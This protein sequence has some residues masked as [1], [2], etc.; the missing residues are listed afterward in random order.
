MQNVMTDEARDK[1]DTRY[2]DLDNGNR[3]VFSK[4]NSPY[5]FWTV[6]FEKGGKPFDL[7]GS[8]TSYD[9]AVQAFHK[10]L[11]TKNE[12]RYTEVKVKK[13]KANKEE[14]FDKE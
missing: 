1:L 9:L 10:Y 14:L 13:T 2:L 7:G 8:Y 6:R 4:A 12:K 11:D 3:A 5:G